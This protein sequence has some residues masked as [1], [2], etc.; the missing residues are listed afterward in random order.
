M[1]STVKKQPRKAAAKKPAK[2]SVVPDM[3]DA[4]V[5]VETNAQLIARREQAVPRGV[6]S[7]APIYAKYAE[8]AELWDVDGNRY[9]DFVGGIDGLR[10]HGGRKG[11]ARQNKNCG[12]PAKGREHDRLLWLSLRP[13]CNPPGPLFLSGVLARIGKLVSRK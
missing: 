1:P 8:N 7:A 13:T 2:S 4:N 12:R 3:L 11:E 6:A 5:S 9:I 10:S